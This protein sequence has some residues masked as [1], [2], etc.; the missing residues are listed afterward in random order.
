MNSYL[1][2][3]NEITYDLC[4]QKENPT[5][6]FIQKKLGLKDGSFSKIELIGGEFP[7]FII[8][9]DLKDDCELK[10]FVEKHKNEVF[11]E[12]IEKTLSKEDCEKVE[13]RFFQEKDGNSWFENI[14][15]RNAG[16]LLFREKNEKIEVL[17]CKP[18]K[19]KPL[20]F[21]GGQ[22]KLKD[23]NPEETALREFHEETYHFY[24]ET[25]TKLNSENSRLTQLG[26]RNKIN[27]LFQCYFVEVP[28]I[29]NDAE[30]LEERFKEQEKK[31]KE[32][33]Q[34]KDYPETRNFQWKEL[35]ALQ[36][37]KFKEHIWETL[38]QFKEWIIK[39]RKKR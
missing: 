36:E 13:D 31:Y 20:Q 22:R 27:S 14:P 25:V 19:R 11:Y 15:I 38:Q 18:Y 9:H 34:Q 37:N 17:V 16:V 2:R 1:L 35:E 28:V 29:E 6:Q 4:E 30:K 32:T 8:V 24:S 3:I 33:Q 12:M 5:P 10:R 7:D 21:F 26:N 23:K 39:I